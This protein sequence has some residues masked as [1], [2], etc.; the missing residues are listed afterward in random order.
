MAGNEPDDLDEMIA[1]R[2]EANPDFPAMVEAAAA[3]RAER[4]AKLQARL[5]AANEGAPDISEEEL[6]DGTVARMNKERA[7]A[8]AR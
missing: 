6:V 3:A 1:K 8:R 4:R 5:E 2:A 7:N